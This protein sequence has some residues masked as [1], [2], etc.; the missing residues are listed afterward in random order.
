MGIVL[1]GLILHQEVFTV[2]PTTSTELEG[3]AEV[4]FV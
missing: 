4:G 2:P 1:L 3:R